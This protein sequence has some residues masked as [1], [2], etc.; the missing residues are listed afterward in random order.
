M[1]FIGPT[2]LRRKSG[3]LA[4]FSRDVGGDRW[5]PLYNL[6]GYQSQRSGIPHLAKNERD[7]AH[8]GF[9]VG[10]SQDALLHRR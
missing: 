10:Q 3:Y 6:D 8:P 7:M 1:R 5:S 2:E 4:G 9:E